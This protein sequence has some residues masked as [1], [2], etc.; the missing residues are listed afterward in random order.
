MKQKNLLALLLILMTASVYA[1]SGKLSGTVTEENGDALISANVIIDAGKGLAAITD[2]DGKY[3]INNLTAGTYEVAFKYIGKEEQKLKVTIAEGQ[4]ATLNVV[5]KEKQQMIDVVVVTGSKYEKKMS[6]ETVSMDVVKGTSLSS[7]N[8]TSLDAGMNRVPGVTIADGQ[9]NIRGGAGWSYGAGSRVQVMIDDLPLL[10][11]DANDAKWDIIPMENVDQVEVIKGAASA[12]YGSGALNGIVNVRT[13]YPVN[14]PYTMVSTYFGI[15]DKPKNLAKAAWWGSNTPLAGGVSFAHRQ[16]FGQND[17]VF[18]AAMNT[19]SGYLDSSDAHAIRGNV[20]YRYRFAKIPGL[21]MGINFTGYYSWGKT[22]FFWNG[23]GNVDDGTGHIINTDSLAYKPYPNTITQYK[24]YRFTVDP[25]I[26]YY[27]KKNNHFRFTGRFFN[28]TNTNN[29]GQGS[30][31]N[32]YY[33]ELQYHRKFEFKKFDFNIVGGAVTNYGDVNPPKGASG[34]LFG[35]NTS[36]NASVYAQADFKFFKRLNVT[37]GARWEFFQMRHYVK[38][39]T[40]PGQYYQRLESKTNSLKDLPYPLFRIGVN[41]QAAEATYIRASFGQGFRYPTIAE[42]YI[43][44]SVGPL[45]ISSNPNLQPEKGYSAELGLKQ[46]FKIG[47]TWTGFG[48]LAFFWN[49]YDNMMEFTFGQFGDTANWHSYAANGGLG[50]SSQNVGK[51]RILGTEIIFGGQ[52]KIGPVGVQVMV[53]YN[54]IDPRSLN[55]DKDLTMYNFQGVQVNPKAELDVFPQFPG[56]E[57]KL[58]LY[59]KANNPDTNNLNHITYGMT[60][61]SKTNILKYRNRHTFKFDLTL[62]YKGF[63]W[64]NNIQYA[65]YMENVDYAFV[66][67]AFKFLGKT[68]FRG[69]EAYRNM[70]E[71]IPVG[72]GRGDVV[73]NTYVAY[74][75]KQGVRISFLVRN[76]LNWEYTP[77]PAY[78]QPPRNYTFQLSYT[79]GGSGKAKVKSN[80]D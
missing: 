51:T 1:Q 22:F 40:A 60:S 36:L 8:I 25:F 34:S 55:W 37:V 80:V 78:L 70:K 46:G 71:A 27:D 54:F 9:V 43:T 12:L 17:L 32:V 50:F 16:K 26:D 52:G 13:A 58:D 18:G 67:D 11:A 76:L 53:G 66:S 14:E 6:E 5:L 75:F 73:W 4:T 74:N 7:Q 62:E 20:K 15:Y 35:K 23:Y 56:Y 68:A 41:Y 44:T 38:D 29:T 28:A 30:V 72:K 63:E 33:A 64:N 45:Y 24:T 21:N 19:S 48:D 31:P 61:T 2:F 77:R 69:L 42:R 59:N 10:T 49:Q 47:K 3:T 65:S 79:F 39:S 57:V